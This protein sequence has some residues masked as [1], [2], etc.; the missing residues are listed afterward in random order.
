[1]LVPAAAWTH[2]ASLTFHLTN[3][4]ES[5]SLNNVDWKDGRKWTAVTVSAIDLAERL[6]HELPRP[7]AH[8]NKESIVFFKFD[9]EGAEFE[10]LPRLISTRVLCRVRFLLIEWHLKNLPPEKRAAGLAMKEALAGILAS[11]CRTPPELVHDD[12]PLNNQLPTDTPGLDGKAALIETFRAQMM[13]A[14]RESN[15]R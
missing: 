15:A 9:V 14:L 1:M 8:E 2:N 6:L 3:N 4:S 10:V 5:A 11:S 7:A 12:M 13:T